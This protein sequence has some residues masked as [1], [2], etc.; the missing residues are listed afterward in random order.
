MKGRPKHP[1]RV[2]VWAE[3]SKRGLTEKRVFKDI[4]DTEFYVTE[5]LSNELL[6][7]VQENFPDGYRFKH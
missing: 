5:I 1:L 7:F 6:S 2:R 4:V 3:I